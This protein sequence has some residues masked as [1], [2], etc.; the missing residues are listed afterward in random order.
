MSTMSATNH[1]SPRTLLRK[2]PRSTTRKSLRF[3]EIIN[4]TRTSTTQ[5]T[6]CRRE[7][8]VSVEK[9][10]NTTST[11]LRKIIIKPRVKIKE[12]TGSSSGISS[13]TMKIQIREELEVDS[14]AIEEISEAE[15]AISEV[16]EVILEAEEAVEAEEVEWIEN[17]EKDRNQGT[18]IETWNNP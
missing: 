6:S 10:P 14:E 9:V 7:K 15:E 12:I 3:A 16:E 2:T 13:R 1:H 11:N 18:S 4:K 8:E 5:T 17:I